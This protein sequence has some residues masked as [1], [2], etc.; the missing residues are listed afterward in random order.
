MDLLHET[1]ARARRG[2]RQGHR[3]PARGRP[4]LAAARL[5]RRAR[6]RRSTRASTRLASRLQ[7]AWR[8]PRR[9]RRP[10]ARARC[11]LAT[12]ARCSGTASTSTRP[13]SPP[14]WPSAAAVVV[15]V[16]LVVSGIGLGQLTGGYSTS[17]TLAAQAVV[18]AQVY[19]LIVP[20][21]TAIWSTRCS[22][23]PTAAGRS[24]A[25]RSS[26]GLEAFGP[27]F[28]AVLLRAAGVDRRL[29]LFVVPGDLAARALVLRPA[30]RG[31]RRP[32]RHGAL[33]RSA[34]LVTGMWWRVCGSPCWRASRWASAGGCSSCPSSSGQG[35]GQPGDR[36]GRADRGLGDHGAVRGADSDAAVLRP[37][38]PPQPA[39]DRAAGGAAAFVAGGAPLGRGGWA[40]LVGLAMRAGRAR[41]GPRLVS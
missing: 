15:P 26:A 24:R 9:D 39:G 41:V 40:G 13:T 28:F 16:E 23:W 11:G 8:A 38:G 18:L 27:V 30:G 1:R 14:S 34:E 31:A 32:P 4:E 22:W 10:A 35:G 33:Q 25:R 2:V 29:F 3:L 6:R 17:V 21:V 20:A 37:P 36:A 19:L 5:L 7:R 12:S